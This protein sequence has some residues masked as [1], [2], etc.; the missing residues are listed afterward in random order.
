MNVKKAAKAPII[1]V[2]INANQTQLMWYKDSGVE[3]L[4]KFL[5]PLDRHNKGILGIPQNHS[6]L[7]MFSWTLGNQKE[8]KQMI[9][10][11]KQKSISS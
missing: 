2:L 3:Y 4:S 1:Q 5:E 10:W 8:S 7:A 9:C 6:I 11:A